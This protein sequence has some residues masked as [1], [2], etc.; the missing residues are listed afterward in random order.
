MRAFAAA[1]LSFTPVVICPD[2]AGQL[3][4]Y[5]W[6]WAPPRQKGM[7]VTEKK[8]ACVVELGLV[9]VHS[10]GDASFTVEIG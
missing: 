8:G 9:R 7:W 6:N 2:P 1:P 3:P 5:P 10:V 4:L